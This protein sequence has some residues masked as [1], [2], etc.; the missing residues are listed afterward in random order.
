MSLVARVDASR[1]PVARVDASRS[2]VTRVD[3]S[4]VARVDVSF[5][6]EHVSNGAAVVHHRDPALKQCGISEVGYC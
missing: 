2:L 1:S 6:G 3:V 5:G 4:L